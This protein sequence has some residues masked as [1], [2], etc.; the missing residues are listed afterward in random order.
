M[1]S[2]T[3]SS[4]NGWKKYTSKCNH[5]DKGIVDPTLVLAIVFGLALLPVLL[6]V[7]IY[8]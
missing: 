7:R 1:S 4:W 8:Q 6:I 5:H 2:D 3:K